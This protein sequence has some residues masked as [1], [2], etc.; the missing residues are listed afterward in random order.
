MSNKVDVDVKL[1]LADRVGILE[2]KLRHAE[3]EILRQRD[4]LNEL[5]R[6][7][8]LIIEAGGINIY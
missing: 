4:E 6:K 7:V 5:R 3:N 2:A 8:N 1:P